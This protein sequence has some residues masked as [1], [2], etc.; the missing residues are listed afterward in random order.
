MTLGRLASHVAEIPHW[1]TRPLSDPEFDMAS[2]TA[3][4]VLNSSEEMLELYQ[5]QMD[6]AIAALE[7]ADEETMSATWTL[8]RGDQVINTLPK[9]IAIRN[10][11][12]NHLVH[13][14]G[15]LSVY[16]RLLDIPVPGVY[17]PSADE[18]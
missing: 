17:G 14:R 1:I 16:L 9:K 11:A 4:A 7:T 2:L 10:M 5:K 15:Q 18:R 3:P 13:H 8:K 6:D 12:M